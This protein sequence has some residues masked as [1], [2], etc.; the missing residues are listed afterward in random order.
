MSKMLNILRNVL[1]RFGNREMEYRVYVLRLP[2]VICFFV[3]LFLS[4]SL[5]LNSFEVHFA[6][7][8]LPFFV[9]SENNIFYDFPIFSIQS[10]TTRR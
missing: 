8:P 3:V 7:N 10:Y 6:R 2:F 9:P 5:S 4:L 1:L